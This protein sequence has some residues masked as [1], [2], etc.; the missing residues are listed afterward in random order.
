M[1]D[2]SVIIPAINEIFLAR[3]IQSVLDNIEGDTE[4]IAVCDGYWPDPPIVDNPRVTMIHY[5]NP[6][7]QRRATNDAA[8]LSR[9]RFIM[10]ADAHCAFDKGFDVK[11]MAN[12]DYD[13]T[14][15]PRM[16]NLHAFDWVCDKCGWRQ[17]QGPQPVKC[18]Q[19]ESTKLVMDVLWKPR[20]NR[21]SDFARFDKEMH[22]Q[23]WGSYAKRPEAQGDIV[24]LMCHVGAC[25]FMHRERYWQLGGCDEAHGSW[26]QMG[27]EVSCKSWLSGGRQVVNK[28]TWFSHMFR[29]QPG[30]TFPYPMSGRDVDV[31]RKH[32]KRLWKEGSWSLAVHP[33][34]W[35]VDKFAPVPDWH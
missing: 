22:F 30:W 35:L 21:R 27:V 10:K 18:G 23:Y 9:S 26:G 5:T 6:V 4:V 31:A 28:K 29:T 25:W 14:V 15:V 2:L 16:F 7:G 20:W 1:A 12:C 32:S 33:L 34:Q 3:T 24:D 8:R 17:Y 11:L 13:W 19:C